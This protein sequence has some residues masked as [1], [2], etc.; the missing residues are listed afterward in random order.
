MEIVNIKINKLKPY[1]KNAKTHPKE[2]IEAIKKS[3]QKY[4]FADPIGVWGKQNIIVEGHGRYLACKELGIDEVPCIRL[5]H[6]T[7]EER[8]EYTLLHNKTTMMSDFDLDLLGEELLELDLSDFELDWGLPELV[9]EE[10][11]KE[12]IEDEVKTDNVPKRTEKGD[13]W[14]LGN[15]YLGCGDST[16]FLW[17]KT[18]MQGKK[19]DLVFT[20]PPYGMKK[21]KDGVANDN[22]NYDKLLEFNKQWIP[23]TFD[24]LKD[25]GSWYCWGIDEP[26]MD[27]YS[28]ILKPMQKENKITFRNFITWKKENDNPTMLFNGACSTNNRSFYSNEKCLFVM[29]G[30][31]GFNNNADNYFEKWEPIRTYLEG[32]A[33]KVGLNNKKLKEICGVEM[34][35]HWFTKSQ[36]GLITEEHYKKLQNYYNDAFKKE[37]EQIKKEWYETRAYFDG[38]ASQCIDVWVHNVTSNEERESAGGHATPKPIVL[39]GRAIKSSS[40]ENEIVLDVFGGSGSTLIACEQLNRICYCNE[41]EPHWC[42]VIINRW[43]QFTGKKAEK[44][45]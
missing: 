30:V 16:D 45:N 29:C 26:L 27:I 37:Y 13:I 5:D 25:N 17:L 32:E 12:L 42:D 8:R 31:Q 6:L 18:L 11:P 3:I 43:E 41:L 23:L 28:N 22:L 19:A 39:C 33:K 1:E 35:G 20:D 38:T 10:K 14:K 4:G 21:E 2:N 34:Y 7:D 9:E 40:R 15:H 44:L 36:W 24:L